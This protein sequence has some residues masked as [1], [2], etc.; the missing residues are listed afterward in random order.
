MAKMSG[1]GQKK[2]TFEIYIHLPFCVKKC[3]YCDFLSFPA[4][5]E[6]QRAYIDALL[7][8]IRQTGRSFGA[9]RQEVSSVFLGGGTPSVLPAEWICE[10]LEE[11]RRNFSVSEN[12]EITIEA[13]PGTVDTGKLQLY[14]TAGINRISF[15][16]QSFHDEELRRLG[17]IHTVQEIEESVQLARGA[18]FANINLDLMS[19]LPGQDLQSWEDTLRQAIALRPE[20][21]SAY[22]LII[23]EGTPFYSLYGE[24]KDSAVF[25]P[26]NEK[27]ILPLPDEETERRMY[28]RTAE[29]LQEAGYAQYEISNYARPGYACRHNRGYWTGV[30]YVGF[31]LGASGYLPGSWFARMQAGS[32]AQQADIG[33]PQ[34]G[35][36]AQ[37]TGSWVRYRNSCDLAEYMS[38]MADIAE[39]SCKYD[40]IQVPKR[41][42]LQAEYMILG[43]RLT[44]GVED[45]EFARRF[46]DSIDSVYGPVLEAYTKTGFLIR[47]NGMTK[48]SRRGI[49]V[50]NRILSEFL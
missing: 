14:R 47:E 21:I 10:V 5:K 3:R 32:G 34:A 33:T 25:V 18:G 36:G 38:G 49:S 15:G 13:N 43:L 4:E 8:E 35:S 12:A 24:E 30:P 20:H 7:R 39:G 11:V 9:G 1:A 42:D 2:G 23:E 44:E 22:S 46:G 27:K 6:Q 19:G 45:A 48:L 31:G 37:Q 16:C 29:I 50:S 40:E 26:E 41:S 17:R 28:E